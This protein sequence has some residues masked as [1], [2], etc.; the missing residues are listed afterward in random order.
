[1][2]EKR[3]REIGIFGVQNGPRRQE[4]SRRGKALFGDSRPS[5]G[6]WYK[7]KREEWQERVLGRRGDAPDWRNM[8]EYKMSQAQRDFLKVE[9]AEKEKWTKWA[10][11]ALP[12]KEGDRIVR[13]TRAL[14]EDYIRRKKSGYNDRVREA[15]DAMRNSPIYSDSRP[16]KLNEKIVPQFDVVGEFMKPRKRNYLFVKDTEDAYLYE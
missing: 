13:G 4:I 10:R 9:R 11:G 6:N 12:A 3:Q 16:A 7:E 5:W 14:K 1:M 8:P 15:G 2:A